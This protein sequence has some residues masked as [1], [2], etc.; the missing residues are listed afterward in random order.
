V[1][2]VDANKTVLCKSWTG[3][4][5]FSHR[6][7]T[8]IRMCPLL[9]MLLLILKFILVPLFMEYS[10]LRATDKLASI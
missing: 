10:M 7:V 2:G 6:F 3:A 9:I 1:L 4:L 5:L 8:Q